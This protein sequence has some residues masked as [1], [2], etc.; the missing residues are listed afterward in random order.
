MAF[1]GLFA[2]LGAAT[3]TS[4]NTSTY[5]MSTFGWTSVLWAHVVSYTAMVLFGVLLFEVLGAVYQRWLDALIAPL[6]DRVT[7][8]L[9][10]SVLGAVRVTVILVIVI[11]V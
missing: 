6:F 3:L 4:T 2:G 10:G 9:A 11:A 7:G 5:L 1:I 8:M